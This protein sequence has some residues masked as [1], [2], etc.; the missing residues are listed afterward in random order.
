MA[1]PAANPPANIKAS[2]ISFFIGFFSF[3]RHHGEGQSS[4]KERNTHEDPSN[5]MPLS[6]R[7]GQIIEE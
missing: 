1:T 6:F 2:R 5:Q 7:V 3:N 4:K